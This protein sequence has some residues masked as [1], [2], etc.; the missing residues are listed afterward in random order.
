MVVQAFLKGLIDTE[1]HRSAAHVNILKAQKSQAQYVERRIA[2]EKTGYQL[3][4]KIGETVL[5][6]NDIVSR[7]S[8]EIL[9]DRYTGP[10]YIHQVFPNSTYIIKST[11]GE[12]VPRHIHGKKLKIYKAPSLPTF[13]QETNKSNE[14]NYP[15]SKIPRPFS[16][17]V[18]P[19][20]PSSNLVGNSPPPPYP[21][22]W[23]YYY[24][25]DGNSHSGPSKPAGP[26]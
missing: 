5:M 17:R 19:K 12:L 2:S 18:S 22:R 4:F 14:S 6:Y 8:S 1:A 11:T 21:L 20:Q 24:L 16:G 9:N 10:Y 3:P 13:I 15:E 25:S 26:N 23:R 7:K